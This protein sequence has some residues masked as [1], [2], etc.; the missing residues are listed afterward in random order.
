MAQV[1][2]QLLGQVEGQLPAN[3]AAGLG[4]Q[5]SGLAVH[6]QPMYGSRYARRRACQEAE[7]KC[8]WGCDGMWKSSN[9]ES[10]AALESRVQ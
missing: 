6:F 1:V 9:A 8:C 2:G 5:P 3:A 7:A 4:Y 10:K